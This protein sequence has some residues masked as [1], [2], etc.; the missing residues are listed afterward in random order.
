MTRTYVLMNTDEGTEE[1]VLAKLRS[2]PGVVE[3]HVTDGIYDLIAEVVADSREAV[4][5]I[6][7]SRIRA[8][9]HVRYTVSVDV[10]D[11]PAEVGGGVEASQVL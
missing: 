9:E 6:L 8:L 7:R 1:E 3:A 5:E 10:V 11:E 2:I 4:K